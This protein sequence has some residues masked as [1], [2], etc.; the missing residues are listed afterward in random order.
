VTHINKS[1]EVNRK[2]DLAENYAITWLWEQNYEVFRNAGR[3]GE[4]DLIAVDPNQVVVKIDVKTMHVFDNGEV[5]IKS[6]RT[7]RQKKIGVVILGF[8]PSTKNCRWIKH[9]D[10]SNVIQLQLAI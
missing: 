3:T 6:C 4:I 8:D 10:H 7:P 5:M 9:A 1:M 2:G